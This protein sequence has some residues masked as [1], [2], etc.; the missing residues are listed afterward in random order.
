MLA[1]ICELHMVDS[2][3]KPPFGYGYYVVLFVCALS[4]GLQAAGAYLLFV[5]SLWKVLEICHHSLSV[6][7]FRI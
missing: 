6:K 1:A 3:N 7:H 4:T 2:L 5:I